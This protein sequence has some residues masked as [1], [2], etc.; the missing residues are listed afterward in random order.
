MLPAAEKVVILWVNTDGSL[1]S[2]KWAGN[3]TEDERL[4][5]V[6][7]S[8]MQQSTDSMITLKKVL[9]VKSCA[10]PQS[11][12]FTHFT[13]HTFSLTHLEYQLSFCGTV[14]VWGQ[15]HIVV[16]ELVCTEV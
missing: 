14:H 2:S 15:M 7:S 16:C 1:G 13:F 11:G 5:F 10:C 4:I 8:L 12:K 9:K 3:I 6:D